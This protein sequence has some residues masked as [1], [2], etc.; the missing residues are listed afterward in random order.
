MTQRCVPVLSSTK[1]RIYN[2]KFSSRQTVIPATNVT[3]DPLFK[4]IRENQ[5]VEVRMTQDRGR[6]LFAQRAFQP[7]EVLFEEMPPLVYQMQ[8][9]EPLRSQL[10]TSE[11]S[12]QD[13]CVHCAAPING[14]VTLSKELSSFK[15]ED[16]M[17]EHIVKS[18]P[19]EYYPLHRT[20][21]HACEGCALAFCSKTCYDQA[22]QQYH[23]LHC[24]HMQKAVADPQSPEARLLTWLDQATATGGTS[25]IWRLVYK[26]LLRLAQKPAQLDPHLHRLCYSALPDSQI[27]EALAV[28]QPVFA[29]SPSASAWLTPE[30]LARLRSVLATNLISL[31]THEPMLHLSLPEPSKAGCGS[32]GGCGST[33]KPDGASCASKGHDHSHNESCSSHSHSH[34]SKGDCGQGSCESKRAGQ[35]APSDKSSG[36]G[37]GSGACGSQESSDDTSVRVQIKYQRDAD[38]RL[39]PSVRAGCLYALAS[40]MNHGCADSANVEIATPVHNT[41]TA[42]IAS[43]AISQGEELRWCYSS[44]AQHVK[45]NYNCE[46]DCANCRSR[47]SARPI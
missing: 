3:S 30:R 5:L 33:P 10:E 37:C 23:Q 24:S 39:M 8:P 15:V 20:E 26:A 2:R 47:V 16:T 19:E 6:G 13:F 21:P 17:L 36:S 28:L 29:E 43:R 46:C 45:D 25:G 7:G 11:P 14:S 4:F 18:L 35:G 31:H 27:A 44:D 32:G 40:Y 34:G 9:P 38:G 1:Y 41:T 22:L 12:E 42:F